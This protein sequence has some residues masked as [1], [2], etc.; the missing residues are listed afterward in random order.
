ML[1][2]ILSCEL[3]P[4][5]RKCPNL[6]DSKLGGNFLDNFVRM[7]IIVK[8]NDPHADLVHTDRSLT[9]EQRLTSET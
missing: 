3:Y 9:T 8:H 6:K 7:R 1:T 4:G 5:G 2:K